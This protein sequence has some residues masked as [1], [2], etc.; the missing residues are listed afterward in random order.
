M[1]AFGKDR[2]AVAGMNLRQQL[3][4]GTKRA[5]KGT[6]GGGGGALFRDQYYPPN[7]GTADIVRLLPGSFPAPRVDF[8]AKD[9]VRDADNNVVVDSLPYIKY[10]EY[11]LIQRK[12]SFVGSEGPLGGFKGKGEPSLASEWYWHEWNERKNNGTDSPQS[13]RRSEKC[14]MSVLVQAPFYHV[15][16]VDKDGKIRINEKTKQP[17]MVWKKG[18]VRGNDE[19]AAGGYEKKNGHVMHWSYNFNH[20]NT[21]TSYANGLACHCRS[22]NAQDSIRELALVCR[23]CGECVVDFQE[24]TLS[25]AE[26]NKIRD[27]EVK[28][29]QCGFHGFLENMIKCENCAHGEEATLFD[30]DLE[31]TQV[32]ASDGGKGYNLMIRKA[33]GPR[34]INGVY[35]ESERKGLDLPKIYS[36]A[37]MEQQLKLLGPLPTADGQQ[38][39]G[40]TRQP[41]NNGSRSYT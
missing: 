11:F 6:G 26:L 25:E 12:F 31:V 10:I 29:H 36:P 4:Q 2:A 23:S 27:E 19:L 15:P 1:S 39:G 9:Y 30:F 5:P 34:P 32:K 16:Q 24:T 13:L 35:G 37:S 20:W 7:D 18:A 3:R 8:D 40:A 28:C 41:V 22:C 33:I 38:Q 17:Y 21:L 14:A